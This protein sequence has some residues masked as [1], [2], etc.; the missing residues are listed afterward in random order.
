MYCW[1]ASIWT[2]PET[3]LI[4]CS[5]RSSTLPS[6]TASDSLLM[7]SRRAA[8]MA[9]A[10]A[11]APASSS[12]PAKLTTAAGLVR[13]LDEIQRKF[14][15]STVDALDIYPEYA[16]FNRPVPGKPGMSVS[17]QYEMDDGEARFTEAGSP[18]PRSG[19]GV[20]I[21]LAPLR[22]NVPTVIGLL[23]GLIAQNQAKGKYQ[24][25]G[26]FLSY[27]PY[28]IMYR[29]GDAEFAEVVEKVFHKLAGSR[30]IVA[31]YGKL[32]SGAAEVGE[33]AYGLRP[34]TAGTME[35]DGKAA[36]VTQ[37][38]P[39]F[40]NAEDETTLD[41]AETIGRMVE[42]FA[43]EKQPQVISILAGVLYTVGAVLFGSGADRSSQSRRR[44]LLC[45]IESARC[46]RRACRKTSHQKI[47]MAKLPISSAT[48]SRK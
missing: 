42:F 20:P 23:Y 43:P 30:E 27:D 13:L 40:L 35:I 8:G 9:N 36:V 17:Y 14:G 39:R 5:I 28:G 10:S 15:D 31:I 16:L 19:N 22:P 2:V 38:N 3:S 45:R 48:R 11:G 18:S 12:G 6:M 4:C 24:V 29:K 33:T 37:I 34:I 32:G 25:I 26:E 44:S 47:T 21:D 46:N 1:F 41:A 7:V